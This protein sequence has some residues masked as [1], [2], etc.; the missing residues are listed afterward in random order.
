MPCPHRPPGPL[1]SATVADLSEYEREFRRAGLPLLIEDYSPAR[2]IFNRAAPLL[3]LVFIG[4]MLGAIDLNWSL[5]ANIAAALGGLAILLLGVAALNRARGR[6]FSA[7]PETLGAPELAGFVIL[8]AL[9]PIVFGGQ[10]LSAVVTALANLL[11]LGLI[12]GVVGFGLLAIVRWVLARL[13][14]QLARSLDLLSRAL[15]LLILFAIVIFPTTEVWEI[16]TET[17]GLNAALLIALLL[18]LG[19][20]FLAVRLPKEVARLEREALEGESH[21]RSSQRL[22]VGLVLFV[23]QALQVLVVSLAVGAFFVLFGMLTVDAEILRSWI[24]SGG[25]ELASVNVGDLHLLL[26]EELLRVS[27]GIAAFTG[28]YFAIS[29]LTDEVYRRE[30]LEELTAEMGETFRRRA[31]YLRLRAG[32][33]GA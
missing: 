23:S 1:K 25:N 33:G 6:P 20:A 9:L 7:M 13:L 14:S 32:L 15:P 5:A 31:E 16:S 19:T 4:E 30:F 18:A 29:M 28:L 27:G 22:N 12:L 24:G 11:L 17:P 3:G 10:W 8:P 2:D 21:L 26:T